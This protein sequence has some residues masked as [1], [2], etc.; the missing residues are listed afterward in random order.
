MSSPPPKYESSILSQGSAFIN[1]ITFIP[2]S[3]EYPHGL[4]VSGG[5]DTVIEVRDPEKSRTDNAE[6]L[7]MGHGNNVCALD[8][9][10]DGTWFVS[11]SW[12]GT[13]RVWSVG[14]WEC[15][16]VLEDHQASVLGV[17]AFDN[18]TIITGSWFLGEY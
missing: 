11:G 18:E 5:Q 10:P 17:L 1:A 3:K 4:V 14:K 13:A 2:P 9:S 6:R 7:L 15:E 12:D 8:I 16:G